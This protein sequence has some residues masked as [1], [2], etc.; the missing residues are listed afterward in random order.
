MVF[1]RLI[2]RLGGKSK[3]EAGIWKAPESLFEDRTDVKA[4]FAAIY[5]QKVWG[6]GSGGGSDP[7]SVGEYVRALQKLMEEYSIQT[8]VDVGCGDWRFSRHIDWTGRSYIGIDVV[9]TVIEEDIR[10]FQSESI[11][12]VCA[13]P[14]SDDWV[15]P[16]CDLMIFKD[17]FQHLSNVNVSRMIARCLPRTKYALITNDFAEENVDCQ[18]GDTR[19]INIRK[20]PFN[21]EDAK[22]V[23]AFSGKRTFLVT[24]EP[25]KQP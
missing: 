10:I 20:P 7:T 16:R 11:T 9:P 12:F 22:E 4:V 13:D 6:G 8:V 23:A 15:I 21:L 17:I 14:L 1:K 19:P 25:K 3:A 18:N 2:R 5:D 24:M